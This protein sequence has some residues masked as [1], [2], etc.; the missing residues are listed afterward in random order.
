MKN[1]PTRQHYV[2]KCYLR[3]F[4]DPTTIAKA[5]PSAWIFDKDGKNKRLDK[6]KNILI[7]KDLYT[8]KIKGKKDYTIEETLAN[9][10]GRYAE[11]FRKKIKNKLPLNPE[12]HIILCA[13]VSV[14]LQR[15]LKHKD[16]L[17]NFYTQLIERAEA[18]EREN[19]LTPTESTKLKKAREDTH[20]LGVV[21]LL[22]D[23]TTLLMDMG[24]AF[25]CA[26]KADFITSDDPCNLFNPD[27]QWQS[28]QGPGLGQQN[29]Q[30]T[31]PLSPKI[32]LCMSWTNMKGYIKWEDFRVEE[33]NRMVRGFCYKYFI[34]N[35][36]KTKKKWFSQYPSLDIFFM[37][38]VWKHKLLRSYLK[39]RR[40]YAHR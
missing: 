22:P 9:L 5:D 32:M 8:L 20:K 33:V 11:I 39:L 31:L 34:S 21:Q 18:I 3:E 27:L 13:F 24:V 37:I 30:V 25:L 23:I 38:K 26:D 4:I 19:N 36:P 17:E 40:L 35:N 1:K 14:M 2:P 12:E 7:S 16:N 6:I 29:V 28:F 10:E 15:T